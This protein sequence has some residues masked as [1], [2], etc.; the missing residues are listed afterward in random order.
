MNIRIYF[1]FYQDAPRHVSFDSKNNNRN[2]IS[3]RMSFSSTMLTKILHVVN[4]S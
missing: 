1:G 4:D 2:V 3:R